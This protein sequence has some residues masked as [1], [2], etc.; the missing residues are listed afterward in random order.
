MSSIGPQIPSHLLGPSKSQRQSD[1][2]SDSDEHE[3][4]Q[5]PPASSSTNIGP[6]IPS[7]LLKK[8]GPSIPTRSD[9]DEEDDDDD[10]M[11]SLPPDLLA[12]R[13]TSSSTSQSKSPAQP[14]SSSSH[15][16]VIGPSFPPPRYQDDS[17]DEIGPAPLP[18]GYRIEDDAVTEFIE[19]EQRR[20]VLA[21]EA[22]KPKTLQRE[23]WMLVPPSS[24]S[25]LGSLDP[26]KMRQA[27]QFSKS[28][29]TP[30]P[31]DNSLWTETPAER[32]QRLADE[33]SGKRRRVENAEDEE[34]G[35][36][37]DEEMRKRRREEEVRRGV[38]EYT[39]KN[40]GPSLINQHSSSTSKSGPQTDET[41]GI[42]DHSRDMG[43]SGRL[44]DDSTRNKIIKDARGLGERFG[45]GRSGGFL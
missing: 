21:E 43:L 34:V 28:S 42:W 10:Y 36:G 9:Q 24:A 13:T 7:E 45:S 8:S 11:P 37:R 18:A 3:G 27:R 5:L 1:S 15:K 19:R 22:A 26:T 25:L 2:D 31:K 20:K 44:L 4:P 39:R 14:S 40:R 33:V 41:P 38:D 30:K 17:D 29:A 32:Q 35:M 16:K 23:E 12:A 6:Q